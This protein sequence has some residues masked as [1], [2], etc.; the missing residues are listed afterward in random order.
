MR[1]FVA[2]DLPEEVVRNLKLLL[3]RLRPAARLQWSRP[4]NLHITT[5]FI[6]EWP[7][8]RLGEL[9]AAPAVVVPRAAIPVHIRQSGFIPNP[10]APRV[11]W[12]GVEASGLDTLAADTDRATSAVGV[13]RDERAFSPHLTLARIKERLNLQ[14]LREAIAALPS[15]DFGQFVASCFFLYQSQLRPGGS[16]YTKLA[17]W[18][19][20]K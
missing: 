17:E 1:L 19:F 7:N 11:F 10:R 20:S 8:E 3:D 13:A 18:K 6:G 15:V 12:C 14:P 5:K 2:L 16:V 4:E 9:R